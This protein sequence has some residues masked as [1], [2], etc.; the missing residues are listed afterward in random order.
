MLILLSILL[1]LLLQLLRDETK[2]N[3]H[4]STQ[5]GFFIRASYRELS[6][7]HYGIKRLNLQKEVQ[8]LAIL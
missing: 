3:L 7:C 2:L 8:F 6:Y 4:H 1:V 5:G